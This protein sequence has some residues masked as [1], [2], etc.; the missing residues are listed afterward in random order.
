MPGKST[1]KWRDLTPVQQRTIVVAGVAELVMTSIALR[2]LA[3]RP[4]AQVRGPKAL[5]LLACFVQPVGPIAYLTVG[6]GTRT[7]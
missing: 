6:R 2:D 7:H 5:W 3:K 4:S 1:K